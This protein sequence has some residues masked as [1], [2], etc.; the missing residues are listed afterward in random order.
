[1]SRATLRIQAISGHRRHRPRRRHAAPAARRQT[2]RHHHLHRL[3]SLRSRLHGVERPALPRN[4]LRQH[5]PDHAGDGVELLEPDPVQRA[6]RTKTARCNGSCAKTS[7][8]TAPTPA[9]WPPV[10]PTT[11]SC[12]TRTASSISSR[13]TASAAS[14]ASPAAPSTSPNS[15]RRPRRCSSARCAMTASRKV[16]N[17]PASKPAPPAACTSA[18]R[19]T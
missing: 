3:Q 8:C 1:M 12:S 15:I 11:P 9:A 18:P 19:K 16:W 4:R 6:R 5:L 2:H 14:T 10:P 17:P 7:A 13:I